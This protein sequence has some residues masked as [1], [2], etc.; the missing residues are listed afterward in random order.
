M[1]AVIYARY[2]S[3][4]QREA[5]IDN[6]AGTNILII[7]LFNLTSIIFHRINLSYKIL[8]QVTLLVEIPIA[9]LIG[10]FIVSAEPA[11]HVLNRQVEEITA[12]AIPA[13][14]MNAALSIGVSVSLA[15]A[16]IRV[17]TGRECS[18]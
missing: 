18:S 9:M 2:S 15:L 4:S 5:S 11:V 7:Y 13:S 10:Y 1:T 12:G 17:L 3:D 16:M 8:I 6:Q 14:A